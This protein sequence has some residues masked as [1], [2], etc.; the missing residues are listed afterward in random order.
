METEID[1]SDNWDAAAELFACHFSC[2]NTRGAA[3]DL[4][5]HI[6]GWLPED[7]R[8]VR[9]ESTYPET[10]ARISA[11]PEAFAERVDHYRNDW[12]NHA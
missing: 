9:L 7:G 8:G 6:V 3:F 12:K 10:L 2:F 4:D 11:D 1:I 5:L